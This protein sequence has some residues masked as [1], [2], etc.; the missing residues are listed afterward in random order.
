M[1]FLMFACSLATELSDVFRG[2]LQLSN[3]SFGVVT[4]GSFEV[5][6]YPGSPKANACLDEVCLSAAANA[7]LQVTLDVTLPNLSWPNVSNSSFVQLQLGP[8]HNCSMK[9]LP[10]PTPRRVQRCLIWRPMVASLPLWLTARAPMNTTALLNYTATVSFW[11][12]DQA[13]IAP[14]ATL[15]A[16]MRQAQLLWDSA[17]ISTGFKATFTGISALQLTPDEQP[18]SLGVGDAFLE[19]SLSHYAL[20]LSSRQ[21]Q[22]SLNSSDLSWECCSDPSISLDPPPA[23]LQVQSN[24]SKS[25]AVAFTMMIFPW[26][27]PRSAP[28]TAPSPEPSHQFPDLQFPPT[29]TPSPLPTTDTNT[30]SD[31]G[32]TDD[33]ADISLEVVAMVL[34]GAFLVCAGLAWYAHGTGG[35]TDRLGADPSSRRACNPYMAKKDKKVSEHDENVALFSRMADTEIEMSAVSV[36]E[37]EE[38]EAWLSGGNESPESKG[39]R[40]EVV[41]EEQVEEAQWQ[42]RKEEI[43]PEERYAEL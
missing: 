18:L 43:E 13:H 12:L 5:P 27:C 42:V 31:T 30:D 20:R 34:F 14:N 19:R 40:S 24:L 37:N 16:R 1:V 28:T 23:T 11:A 39:N 22:C 7:L 32:S 38:F 29:T 36:D 21:L 41:T 6:A 8:T 2:S 15:R 25:R 35:S 9:L 4:V 33:S 26:A 17:P 3:N 10:G